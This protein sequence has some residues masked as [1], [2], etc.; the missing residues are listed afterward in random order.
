[1]PSLPQQ[2]NGRWKFNT[3]NF[4][5]FNY[6]DDDK[7]LLKLLVKVFIMLE[8]VNI[9]TKRRK[10]VSG[11]LCWKWCN[12]RTIPTAMWWREESPAR[13][14]MKVMNIL[15][16]RAKGFQLSVLKTCRV[17]SEDCDVHI[18]YLKLTSLKTKYGSVIHRTL[19]LCTLKL[20]ILHS[21]LV[22]VESLQNA[23][24]QRLGY[25]AHESKGNHLNDIITQFVIW[26]LKEKIILV[27]LL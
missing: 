19:Q 18:L 17:K 10:H 12:I 24:F 3:I 26:I 8:S 9:N 1:M 20:K 6:I 25:H 27:R 7:L 23:T 5:Y 22:I 21:F 14:Q 13:L 15:L 16:T 4:P 2:F 11:R